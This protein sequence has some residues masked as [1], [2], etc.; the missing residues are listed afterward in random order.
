MMSAAGARIRAGDLV[1]VCLSAANRD[2]EVFTDPDRYDIRRDN[3]A[4]HLAF[5]VGPHY[6]L[7]VHLATLQTTLARRPAAGA[8]PRH[9][10][11]RSAATHHRTHLPQAGVGAGLTGLTHRRGAGAAPAVLIA[12]VTFDPGRAGWLSCPVDTTVT[13]AAGNAANPTLHM[14]RLSDGYPPRQSTLSATVPT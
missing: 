11:R 6:C 8:F 3:A 13:A 5:A 4:D 14:G 9:P 2:P 10:P 1:I 7:G 12:V